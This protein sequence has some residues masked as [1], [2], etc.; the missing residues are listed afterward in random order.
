MF[1]PQGITAVDRIYDS[2]SCTLAGNCNPLLS[3]APTYDQCTI[4]NVQ[5]TLQSQTLGLVTWLTHGGG[6][7]AAA[8]MNTSTATTLKMTL[9]RLLPF[10]PLVKFTSHQYQ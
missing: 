1:S 10:R 4:P 6:T 3:T 5:T 8:V 7:G 9:K 2:A